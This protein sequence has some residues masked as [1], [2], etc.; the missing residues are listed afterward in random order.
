[1]LGAVGGMT[2]RALLSL[3][4]SCPFC[5]DIGVCIGAGIG[6]GI[7]VCDVRGGDEGG[8]AVVHGQVWESYDVEDRLLDLEVP[9]HL[10]YPL[11]LVFDML[12]RQN[13]QTTC[14]SGPCCSESACYKFSLFGKPSVKNLGC[15]R[16][17]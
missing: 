10:L 12:V 3:S 8:E 15:P 14:L 4:W 9:V 5:L 1:M 7:G 11:G 17:I 6:V 16:F 2:F 13:Y